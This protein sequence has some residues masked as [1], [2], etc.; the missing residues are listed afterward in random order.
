MKSHEGPIRR[1]SRVCVGL[2]AAW[3]RTDRVRIS[4]REGELLRLRPG[5]VFTVHGVPAEVR[6]RIVVPEFDRPRVSYECQ[7]ELGPASLEVD[8]PDGEG[9]SAIV[10]SRPGRREVL[11]EHQIEVFG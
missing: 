2:L 10:W 4:P 8:G 6:A 9:R 7:T 1:L 11:F 5:C 3:W